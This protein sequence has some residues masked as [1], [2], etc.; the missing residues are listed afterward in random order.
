MKGF[1]WAA[2]AAADHEAATAAASSR[3]RLRHFLDTYR[4][5]VIPSFRI[6][7]K[8]NRW[9]IF[10]AI[11]IALSILGLAAV[12]INLSIDFEGGTL[13][14]YPLR[15]EV[16]V[17]DI[18]ATLAEA[19]VE[20]AEVQLVTD[21]EGESVVIRTVSIPGDEGSPLR[22]A[23]AD[24]AGVTVGDVSSETV[25]PTWGSEVS[26][27][28][29]RGLIIVLLLIGIYIAFR[30]QPAMALGAMVALVHDVVITGG[31]Y[32][33][34]AREVTPETVIAVLTILGFSL[35]DTVVIYDKIQE[36]T[37]SPALMARM[38]YADVVNLSLNQ[39]IMRSVNTSLV[40]L[41]PIASL[42]LFG[43]D[44]LKDFA[45]AMFVGT[46]I[47]AYSSIFIAAPVLVLLRRRSADRA[48]SPVPRSARQ[49]VVAAA[50]AEG[51]VAART[52]ASSPRPRPKGKGRPQPKRK[53][54]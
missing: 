49:A 7:E 15:A 44:T 3:S 11:L 45:F 23:L 14:A 46:T 2:A 1:G 48:P 33:L 38:S 32:A 28:A 43:G 30:F 17:D 40:V 36:N 41:L 53:R 22:E 50:A 6:V 10:S 16:T 51:A 35:Y 26:R 39:T 29:L 9:F 19:G 27:T 21:R 12:R 8:M 52:P 47:G 18:Q 25:G 4:G 5:Y 42:L 24:Q 37:E 54:R 13:L 31:I 34:T 20:Q